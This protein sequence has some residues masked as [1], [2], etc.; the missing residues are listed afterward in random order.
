MKLKR[1]PNAVFTAPKITPKWPE[2][3][4]PKF[5]PEFIAVDT[6]CTGLQWYG[7]HKPYS[8]QVGWFEEGKPR[9]AVFMWGVNCKTREPEYCTKDLNLFLMA[10]SRCST[11]FEPTT[12]ERR[13][14]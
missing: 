12:L 10:K 8:I 14:L 6:E 4:D 13:N 2:E 11:N 7:K 3:F 9:T 1:G 5:K